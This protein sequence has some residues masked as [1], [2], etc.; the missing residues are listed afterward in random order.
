MKCRDNDIR[1]VDVSLLFFV[2]VVVV[3][4][5]RLSHSAQ[6]VFSPVSSLSIYL[7]H[8][9][10]FNPNIE[11]QH[12]SH[13]ESHSLTHKQTNTHAHTMQLLHKCSS[14]ALVF[15]GKKK[16]SLI[17]WLILEM[18]S[19]WK[20]YTN[21]QIVTRS[22]T[23]ILCALLLSHSNAQLMCTHTAHCSYIVVKLFN[24]HCTVAIHFRAFAAA[25]D[26]VVVVGFFFIFV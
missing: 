21:I 8:A 23:H 15:I 26:V 14:L 18:R 1:F 20:Q 5:S 22:R 10:V 3:V 12:A 13:K 2:V 17:L 19:A 9:F 6:C 16:Q 4:V 24:A 11:R 25:V 7:S